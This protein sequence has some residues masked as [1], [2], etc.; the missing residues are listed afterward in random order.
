MIKGFTWKMQGSEFSA[1]VLLLPLSGSDL[2]L[3]IQWFSAFGPVLW[4]FKNLT[5]EFQK[6]GRKVKLRGASGKKLKGMQASKLNKL[7]VAFGELSMMQLI[8]QDANLKVGKSND[9][10]PSLVKLL[11]SY[12]TIFEEP[13]GLPPRREGFDHQIPLKE[14]SNHINLRPYRYPVLQKNVIEEMV[15]KLLDQGIIRH[16]NSPFAAPIVL[17][18]KKMEGGECVY[19]SL[20]KATVKDKFP[21]PIIEE[22]LDEVKGTCYFSKIDLTSRYHQMRMH[23]SDVQKQPSKHIL[24]ILSI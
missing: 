7:M 10:D 23:P 12:A 18:K 21:I 3:G 24:D 11:D 8:P 6:E 20:N 19:R 22:L 5:M 9:S 4:D 2:V 1:N 14:G 15:Q 17:V 13:K 16:S